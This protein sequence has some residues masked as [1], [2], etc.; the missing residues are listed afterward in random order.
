MRAEP[1]RNNK[2]LPLI[3]MAVCKNCSKE[4]NII[5][6]TLG[7]CQECIREEFKKVSRHIRE[8]HRKTRED[9]D[10]PEEPPREVDGAK[11]KLCVNECQISP[12]GKGYCGLRENIDGKLSGPSEEVAN[13]TYYHDGLPA[14]CVAEWVC[15]GGTGAGYP[16][17]A[18]CKD[19]PEIGYKN[20]AVFYIGCSLNCLFCQNWHFREKLKRPPKVNLDELLDAIDSRTS[21]ICYFGGDPTPQILH[22]I[23]FARKALQ[24]RKD[25]IL[26]I[27]WETNGSMD[28][29]LLEEILEI[30][31]VSGGCV[32]F[33][34]KTY[35]ERLNLA[36]CGVTN[37]RTLENFR[38]A[39]KYI[40]KRKR[41][42]LLIASTL[43]VP[44]Y[45]DKKEVYSIAKFI[46]GLDRSI[47]Y[48][49]L[50]FGP[51]FYMSDLPYT[52]RRHAEDCLEAAHKAGLLNVKIGNIHLLGRDYE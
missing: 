10:L 22:S 4:S 5:S 42:P 19:G 45:V 7:V 18:Y 27:C 9:F 38:L 43:L 39:S 40:K 6:G 2:G 3:N 28:P 37:K 29:R 8:V 24:F 1:S 12:G 17:F 52:S 32:K 25:K 15:P 36:L 44:G 51:N 20:L 33:D 48:S 30:A 41:P 35:D 34:L 47:P 16:E 14:N 31:L 23:K 26:R 13:L 21:C 50:G 49:L 11:C 46:S